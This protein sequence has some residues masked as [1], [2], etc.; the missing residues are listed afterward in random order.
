MNWDVNK[1]KLIEKRKIFRKALTIHPGPVVE[2][3][4]IELQV[5]Q[6]VHG[7]RNHGF[8][9]STRKI[10]NK[11]LQINLEFKGG[12]VNTICWWV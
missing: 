6:W 12:S 2:N 9:I 5:R 10:I 11:V 1:E 7:Q 3:Q 8:V 4:E